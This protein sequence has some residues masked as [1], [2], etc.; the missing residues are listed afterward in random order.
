VINNTTIEKHQC[1]SVIQEYRANDIESQTYQIYLP[2]GWSKSSKILVCVHGIS[3]KY[4]QQIRLLKNY[5]SRG[6]TILVAPYFSN[7]NHHAF[8]R[9]AIGTDGLRSNQVLDNIMADVAS[10]YDIDTNKFGL[11][12]FSAGAQFAHR[13][14][15]R[16]PEKITELTTCAAGWYTMPD[17]SKQFPYG[18][19]SCEKDESQFQITEQQLCEFLRIP[20]TVAVGEYDK[21]SDSSMNSRKLINA[22]QGYDRMERA[23]SWA[24][25]LIT[26]AEERQIDSQI[27]FVLIP[28]S[29][30]S[31]F[32]CINYGMLSRYLFDDF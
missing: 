28:R 20:I 3:R 26:A 5:A 16:N 27:K 1:N 32:E 17:F 9:H 24:R 7:K 10:R 31:F 8:Q 2:E 19:S 11:C 25:S 18:L 22:S 4:K 30:H 13:Y 6:D 15:L 21:R 29:G 12:G 23:I 14:A